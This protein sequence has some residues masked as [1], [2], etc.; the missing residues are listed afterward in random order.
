MSGV[1]S[2]VINTFDVA[3]AKGNVNIVVKAILND[4]ISITLDDD[5]SFTPLYSGNY[6]IV[7]SV[8]D[9][10]AKRKAI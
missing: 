7:V 8:S 4:E 6:D 10:I 3:N 1:K 9:Y 2:K 5:Y